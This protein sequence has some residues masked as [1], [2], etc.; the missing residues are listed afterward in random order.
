MVAVA[1]EVAAARAQGIRKGP[2]KRPKPDECWMMWPRPRLPCF[3]MTGTAS[4]VSVW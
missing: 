1:V 3:R 2:E 4:D